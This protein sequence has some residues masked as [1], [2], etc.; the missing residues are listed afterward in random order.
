MNGTAGLEIGLPLTPGRGG[1]TPALSYPTIRVAVTANSDSG[2]A[3]PCPLYNDGRTSN[4]RY[5]MTKE[6]SDVFLL[7]GAED[8]VPYIYGATEIKPVYPAAY[9][10]KRYRPRIEGLF[11]RIEYIKK[12]G[13]TDSWWRVTT[14][15]N[16]TTYYGLGPEA[17][18]TDPLY[19]TR[20]FKWLPQITLDHKGNVQCFR[21]KAENQDNI[22][23]V[24][25]EQNRKGPGASFAQSYL[26]RVQYC[27]KQP[28]FTTETDTYEPAL[29]GNSNF[30]M[31]AIFDY[32]D[33]PDLYNPA[34]PEQKWPSRNDAFSDFHAG[35]EI[36]T[37][38]KCRGISM[39]HYFEELKDMT[40]EKT[41]RSL[42]RSLE[43]SYKNDGHSPHMLAEA[44]FIIAAKQTGYDYKNNAS[45]Q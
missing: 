28:W 36:R 34:S 42:V 44:D 40:P 6:E 41:L 23:D 17:R 9:T 29:P 37:Y 22:A 21:Y 27:N 30:L 15:D 45:A 26:K 4:C 33:Q 16:I 32:G 2:G 35:F 1:F 43:L 24:V 31:E 18:I 8:L 25:F 5:T 14:K 38:R 13:T 3:F 11:A 39:Y 7:A 10:I 12:K 19:P 20:T